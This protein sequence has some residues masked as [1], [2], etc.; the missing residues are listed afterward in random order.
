MP[1]L[2]VVPPPLVGPVVAVV[3]VAVAVTAVV[4]VVVAVVVVVVAVG[5]FVRFIVDSPTK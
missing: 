5:N 2:R 3:S 1:C 4:V